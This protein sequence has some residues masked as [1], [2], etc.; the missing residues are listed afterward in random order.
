MIYPHV[1]TN[2]ILLRDSAYTVMHACHPNSL[3]VALL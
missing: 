3:T 1:V 2:K